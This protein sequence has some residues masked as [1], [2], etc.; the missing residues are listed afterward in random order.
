MGAGDG[1]QELCPGLWSLLLEAGHLP[2]TPAG[3]SGRGALCPLGHRA[4]EW[5]QGAQLR[6]WTRCPGQQ[7]PRSPMLDAWP[8]AQWLLHSRYTGSRCT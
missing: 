4:V 8:P 6:L 5:G 1:G 2:L 3:A 7:G